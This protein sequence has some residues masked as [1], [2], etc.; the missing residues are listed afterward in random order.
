MKKLPF[1]LLALAMT[2]CQNIKSPQTAEQ[3]LKNINFPDVYHECL[4][5]RMKDLNQE[6]ESEAATV[7]TVSLD[8]SKETLDHTQ[9]G[10]ELDK[11][12]CYI[13]ASSISKRKLN[14][15]IDND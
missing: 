11:L 10:K 1:V 8:F 12:N 9:I 6:A 13:Y 7:E 14:I 5:S 2:G 15:H 3:Q 4:D